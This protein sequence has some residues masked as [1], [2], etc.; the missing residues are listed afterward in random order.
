MCGIAGVFYPKNC[1]PQRANLAAMGRAMR[2]RGPDGEKHHISDDLRYQCVFTRLAIIDVQNSA[3]PIVSADNKLVLTGNGEIYNYKELRI[4][5]PDYLY[6]TKGDMEVILPLYKH[7]G[8]KCLDVLNG[9]FALALF[10]AGVHQLLLARDH[11]GIKPLYWTKLQNGGVAFASEI[12]ALFA[13][14]LVPPEIDES[15]IPTYLAHGYI[16]AP[17]TLFKRIHKLPP[18]HR[19]IVDE[20]GYVSCTLYWTAQADKSFD[21]H[22]SGLSDR[23]LDL[24]RD[25]IRLQL[26]SDVPVGA[27]LSGGLDSGL[28]VALAAE[29]I[30]SQLS[31]YTVRFGGGALDESPFAKTIAKRHGV[32]NTVLDVDTHSIG[33]VLPRLLWHLEE[34]LND[35]SLLPNFLIEETLGQ[36]LR[37]ALNGTGGDELFAGYNRYFQLPIEKA[38]LRIP[39]FFRDS[40]IEPLIEQFDPMVTWRLKRAA[41]FDTHRGTYLFEHSAH[42]PPPVLNALNGTTWN[43]VSAQQHFYQLSGHN[44]QVGGLIA[45]LNTYLPE[46]LLLLLDRTSMAVSVEGR[47]PFLD[48]R[49]VEAALAVPPEL[50]TPQDT[51]KG[52]QRQMCAKFLPD[53]VL[54]APK[55]GFA[56]PVPA[57]VK[58]PFGVQAK[59]LLLSPAALN[60]GWWSRSGVL[61]LF[62]DPERHAFRIYSLVVLEVIVRVHIDRN[63]P[64]VMATESLEDLLDVA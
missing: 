53:E 42:F 17:Q 59:R 57:W 44:G 39:S 19:L 25:S 13:S 1:E 20:T 47:V 43:D 40:F 61:S 41:K 32:K 30:G 22:P 15:T 36:H 11:L 4:D 9:M 48:R 60:R 46:D 37:V 29:Q 51:P 24:L 2:H 49:F 12:K 26:R 52:L 33:A 64:T 18:G 38:Y 28:M 14:G 54:N 50:R 7:H 31:T 63:K 8:D 35:A 5:E 56:S 3:Q 6:S 58:G 27:L 21:V 45:E 16:P 10:D 34:P 23:L 62:A 55:Q